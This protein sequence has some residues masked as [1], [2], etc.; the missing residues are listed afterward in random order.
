MTGARLSWARGPIAQVLGVYAIVRVVLLI[1]DSLAAHSSYAGHLDG[2]LLSWD[3]GHY[4]DI[5]KYG[6]PPHAL[7]V[8]GHLTYQAGG[9]DP[10]FP[11]LIRIVAG[12]GLSFTVSA[13]VVSLIA[14][15]A[16]TV[17]LFK[18]AA[19][20][21]DEVIGVRS[22]ILFSVL[23]GMGVVWGS[24]YAE[25]VGLA[26]VAGCLFLM[27]RSHWVP[28]GIFGALASATN[29]MGIVLVVPA[30]VLAIQAMVRRQSPRALITVALVPVGFLGF[31]L[32]LG[33]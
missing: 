23:P 2:P 26:F 32:W 31:A 18:L 19:T 27:A 21:Y 22:A 7:K 13:L 28:A 33:L 3:A 4:V 20:L 30:G 12:T 6:Y 8:D 24:F 14:G 16:A 25:C 29:P 15:A 17:L 5:A 1:A 11:L 10:V 9:F